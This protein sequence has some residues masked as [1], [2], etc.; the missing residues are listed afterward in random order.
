MASKT[1]KNNSKAQAPAPEAQA[2]APVVEETPAP[3]T[4][5]KKAKEPRFTALPEDRV[6]WIA[7][8]ARPAV[9]SCLCGCGGTTKGRFMP[10]HDATLKESLKAGTKSEDIVIADASRAALETFG[11]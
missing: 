1:K 8:H 3:E 2:P 4:K 11:W 10:G 7:Q 6:L 5:T 9:S